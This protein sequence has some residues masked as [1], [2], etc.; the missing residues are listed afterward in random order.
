M[1]AGDKMIY[2]IYPANDLVY[3]ST[4]L[5]VIVLNMIKYEIKESWL[6][7]NNGGFVKSNQFTIDN[8]HYY[9]ATDQGLKRVAVNT[10]NPADYNAWEVVSGSN[11][12]VAT[13]AKG[14]VNLQGKIIVL[15]ND[16]LFVQKPEMPGPIFSV[17]VYPLLLLKSPKIN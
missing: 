10:T 3:L 4:G 6:I 7:G 2:H 5:G 13:A 1:T 17:M 9:A 16:S 11:G 8:T 15:Q 12:L 14:V